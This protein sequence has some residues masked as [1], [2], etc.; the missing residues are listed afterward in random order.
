[1]DRGGRVV[2]GDHILFLT[3]RRL[4]RADRL[5]GSG[6]VATIMSNLWLEQSLEAFD[7]FWV[8]HFEGSVKS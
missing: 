5:R 8:K 7:F 1:M 2:D 4:H 3:G 6:V